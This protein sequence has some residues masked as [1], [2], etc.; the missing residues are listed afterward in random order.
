ML[1]NAVKNCKEK[2]R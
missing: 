1:N 2:L